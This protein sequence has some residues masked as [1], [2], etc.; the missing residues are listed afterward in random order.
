MALLDAALVQAIKDL[1]TLDPSADENNDQVANALALAIQTY[2]K[3]G[4]VVVPSGTGGG[5][6]P[7]L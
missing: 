7:V 4:T 6:Y 5:T 3:T 1:S 2:V